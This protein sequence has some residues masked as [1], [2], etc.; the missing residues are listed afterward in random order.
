MFF[1]FPD[2]LN[3]FLGRFSESQFFHPVDPIFDPLTV[4]SKEPQKRSISAW[5]QAA[6]TIKRV[7][8]ARKCVFVMSDTIMRVY[9]R[10]FRAQIGSEFAKFEIFVFFSTFFTFEFFP[11]F[12]EN[13]R[14][15]C[16][17]GYADRKIVIVEFLVG[18]F[19][20]RYLTPTNLGF[21]EDTEPWNAL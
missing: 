19:S 6:A 14:W 17:G 16:K 10:I 8:E 7:F 13:F 1:G 4:S 3:L 18:N 12:F 15:F 9:V 11:S 2:L 20:R 21:E 5:K